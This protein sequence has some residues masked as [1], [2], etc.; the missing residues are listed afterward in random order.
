MIARTLLVAYQR[1]E[2]HARLVHANLQ[3]SNQNGCYTYQFTSFLPLYCA[4]TPFPLPLHPFPRPFS[5]LPKSTYRL[6]ANSV[7]LL[8]ITSRLTSYGSLGICII[9]FMTRIITR[10]RRGEGGTVKRRGAVKSENLPL[11]FRD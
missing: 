7:C 8:T 1:V 2:A 5:V 4:H 10:G 9:R 3:H 11:T 6:K